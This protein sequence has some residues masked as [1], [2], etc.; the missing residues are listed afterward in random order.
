VSPEATVLAAVTLPFVA[1]LFIVALR[2]HPD[3]RESVT[4]LASGGLFLLVFSLLGDV[5]KGGA[6]A[7]VLVETLPGLSIAFKVEPLGM[8]F[9]LLAGF[10]WIVTSL[11]SIGYMRAHQAWHQ[12]RFYGYFAV[13]LGSAMGIAFAGNLFTLFI[14]YEALTLSTYPLVAHAGTDAARE[15]ARV[16]LGFLLGT[17]VALFLLALVWTRSLT[18]TL[19]FRPGGILQ[20]SVTPGTAGVLL[21]LYVFGIGKAALMPLH[22]WLPAAMVAPTPVSALLHAVA[23]VKAGVFAILKV[24]VYIFGVDF[25]ADIPVTQWL[26]YVAALTVLLASFVALKQDN[27]KRRLAYSTIS[28][29][30]YIILGALLA[31]PLGIVGGGMHMVMH[32]FAKITLFFC[33]GAILVAT[34]KTQVSEMHGLGRRMPITMGAFFVASLSIIG[35]PPLGGFWSKWFL[36]LG[37]L[38]AQQLVMLAVLLASSMLNVAY[39]LTIPVR[40]FF[41]RDNDAAGETGLR[42]APLACVSALLLTTGGC[43]VLFVA[44]GPVYQ[45]VQLVVPR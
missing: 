45:L 39:L 16:Y 5:L 20:D 9:A 44:P 29:L 40:A 36:A 26:M 8:L 37:A 32:A 14:F 7:A 19:D 24:C 15:G 25:L 38:D 17:S 13:A 28:Q 41:G 30:S 35:L 4:L 21:V 1:M 11:F 18:G 23:V 3:L 2:R 33:A 43:V 6:P 34:R 12:T 27:L 10:L 31:T 22:R 42:E